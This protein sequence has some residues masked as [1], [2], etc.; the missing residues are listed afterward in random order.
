MARLVAL[1]LEAPFQGTVWPSFGEPDYDNAEVVRVTAIV[2]DNL[3]IARAQEGQ[4]ARAII[5]GDRIHFG[6]TKKWWDDLES[7]FTGS[8]FRI[9]A[10]QFQLRGND[11]EWYAPSVTLVSGNPSL[12]LD[13]VNGNNFRVVNNLFQ[14]VDLNTSQWYNVNVILVNGTPVLDIEAA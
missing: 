9:E 1:G 12:T 5:V 13:P 4:P 11:D 7:L 6:P 8:N 3:T 10:G 2:G 14:L